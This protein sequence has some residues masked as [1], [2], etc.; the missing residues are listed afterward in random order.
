MSQTKSPVPKQI[1]SIPVKK[2]PATPR[3]NSGGN[4]QDKQSFVQQ[5][6]WQERVVKENV[7]QLQSV[8]S[9]VESGMLETLPM[10]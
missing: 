7:L 6:F 10:E 8:K 1:S 3:R 5:H 4:P 2:S 9:G